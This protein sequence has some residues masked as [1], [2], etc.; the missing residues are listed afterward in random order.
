MDREMLIEAAK[1]SC[2]HDWLTN[3]LIPLCSKC[4]FTEDGFRYFN[5]GVEKG[6]DA[7]LSLLKWK[8]VADGLPQV[9]AI[10]PVIEREGNTRFY[11]YYI[12][13]KEVWVTEDGADIV[14]VIAYIPVPIPE[15]VKEQR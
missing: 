6:F 5:R 3:Y 13:R 9:D 7:A 15:Y 8:D 2:E 4:G 10:Y 12:G 1:R 11:A 14:N